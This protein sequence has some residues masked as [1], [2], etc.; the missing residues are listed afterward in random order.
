MLDAAKKDG[1][2]YP[3]VNVSSSTTLNAA[4]AG[5]ADAGSDGIVQL[6]P[7]GAEFASGKAKDAVAGAKAL[8]A[9]ACEVADD[10]P[11]LIALHTDYCRRRRSMPFYGR[12][13]KSR[14]RGC[15]ETSSPSTSRT[16]STA[17]RYF[18]PKT[19]SWPPSFCRRAEKRT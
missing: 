4:L 8:A 2:A 13:S 12:C 16:C 14:R 3:A 18:S 17:P 15:A 5:F 10:Y 9:F 19:W 7:S 6:T 11:V 1:Y